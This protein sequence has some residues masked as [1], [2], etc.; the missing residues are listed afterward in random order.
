MLWVACTR[1]GNEGGPRRT[2]WPGYSGYRTWVG[3]MHMR[4]VRYYIYRSV[5]LMCTLVNPRW[6]HTMDDPQRPT[7]QQR[8]SRTNNART[9]SRHNRTHMTRNVYLKSERSHNKQCIWYKPSATQTCTTQ[10]HTATTHQHMRI[11]RT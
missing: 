3:Y 11:N 5:K 6:R 2:P 10:R 8:T 9:H 4:M 7:T 1:G